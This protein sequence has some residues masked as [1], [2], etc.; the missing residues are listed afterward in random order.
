MKAIARITSALL[1]AL[2]IPITAGAE[3]RRV[4]M[5]TLGMD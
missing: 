5:K 4:E 3:L 2:S 1:L